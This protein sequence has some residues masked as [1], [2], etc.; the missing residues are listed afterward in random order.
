M[1]SKSPLNP[2]RWGAHESMLAAV[3]AAECIWRYVS[4][5][6]GGGEYIIIIFQLSKRIYIALNLHIQYIYKT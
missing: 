4:G 6:G 3:A 5:G 2:Q 1:Y